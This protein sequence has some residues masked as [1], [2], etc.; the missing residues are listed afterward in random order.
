MALDE[1]LL[2]HLQGGLTTLAR[3][4]A[5]TRT[6]GTVYGFTDHDLPMVF[7]GITFRADSGMSSVGLQQSTGLSVDNTE[8]IG[9]LS[10]A[11]IREDDI[12]AGRFDGA[13][14]QAWLVNWTDVEIRHLIFRGT[15]GELRRAGGQFHAELRGLSE[16]LNRPIG[17][18]F[19]KPCTAVL[20]DRGCGFGVSEPGYT[21][22][23]AVLSQDAGRQYHFDEM[24]G[25]EDRWFQRG[26][27]EVLTGAAAGL[28]GSIKR[29]SI[30]ENGRVI[31]LWEPIRANVEAGD[32]VR[33][34]AGCDKRFETCRFKFNNVV[35]FQGFPDIPEEDWM[36][37]HPT[38]ATSK[39]GG[40]RR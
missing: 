8:A 9:A 13:E 26:R 1:D 6:D 24:P 33:L 3:A 12:L 4:W 34:T 31:A 40:S 5:I 2:A 21:A 23:V 35:N 37:I 10:D 11:S 20:G 36:M 14:V 27:F 17:R 16:V 15:L 32:L 18:V 7:D 22:D 28:F 25:F 19:Q 30:E 39:D 29:D 38:E